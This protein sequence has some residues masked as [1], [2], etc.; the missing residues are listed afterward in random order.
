ML[1][2]ASTV[3]VVADLL[4]KHKL[5]S[6]VV[7]PVRDIEHISRVGTDTVKVMVAT[8]GAQLLP[9]N[10]IETLCTQL[11]PETLLLTPNV[12]EA[13]LIAQRGGKSVTEVRN[14]E[15][16]E[17]LASAVHQLGPRYVLL[18]GG[19]TPL[20]SDHQVAKS[21]DEKQI[22]VNVLHGE[23]VTE[24]FETQYQRSRN[25]HGTG[26]SLACRS[27]TL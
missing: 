1:A 11:L 15:G 3:S 9:E 25:T 22:V 23:G 4:R 19:H 13:K 12:P 21:D 26:C 10:A 2:S 6:S 24:V 17:Q 7:D 16:L 5:S 14:L 18:K 8:S 20:T 27:S